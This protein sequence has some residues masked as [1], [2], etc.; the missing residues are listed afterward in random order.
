[1]LQYSNDCM[2]LFLVTCDH[3]SQHFVAVLIVLK[4]AWKKPSKI[5]IYSLTSVENDHGKSYEI[6]YWSRPLGY[7]IIKKSVGSK[8]SLCNL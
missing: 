6:F 5:Y 7:S 4:S 8:W 3:K 2:I 1:M